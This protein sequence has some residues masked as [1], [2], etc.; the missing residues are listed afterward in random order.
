MSTPV[1]GGHAY[2]RERS[3]PKYEGLYGRIYKDEVF[4]VEII[5]GG[6]GRY[7]IYLRRK[8]AEQLIPV[9][10]GDVKAFPRCVYCNKEDHTRKT[11][12]EKNCS[13]MGQNAA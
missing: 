4:I 6:R 9:W 7:A 2:V 8:D 13:A 10:L 12:T 1:V 5:E 11:A 3:I